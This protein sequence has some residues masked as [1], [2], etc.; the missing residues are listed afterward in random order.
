[1]NN[2]EKVAE[3]LLQIPDKTEV[4]CLKVNLRE[5]LI[6]ASGMIL[7]IYIDNRLIQTFPMTRKNIARLMAE[8]LSIAGFKPKAIAGVVSGGIDLA[9]GL[10]DLL[11]LPKINV[12]PE[13][14]SHGTSQTIEGVLEPGLNY[15]TIDDAINTGGSIFKSID[16]IR[17]AGGLVTHAL[18]V[19]NYNWVETL[20][21]F[22]GIK[23][24]PLCL[25]SLSELLEQA[26]RLGQIN[27][28]ETVELKKWQVN[29]WSWNKPHG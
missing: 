5:P 19:V 20:K 14:K 18:A 8:E 3:I 28:A 22:E 29:P 24:R 11:D 27:Q 9:R 21:N 26:L 2:I 13:P 15:L 7:P 10:A 17:E 12:R 23:V 6:G 16:N 25:V 4:S 1:M